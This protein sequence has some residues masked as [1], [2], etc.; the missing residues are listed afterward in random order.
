MSVPPIGRSGPPFFAVVAFWA[1]VLGGV[2]FGGVFV[3]N[4][5]ALGTRTVDAPISAQP[6]VVTVAAGPVSVS[7]PVSV[8]VAI[9]PG[10]ISVPIPAP[11]K[12]SDITSSIAS[13]VKTVLPDWQGSDRI[14]ILLLG[15][16]KRDD[17]PVAGTRS[18]TII[19]ASIDPVTKSAS[20]VS[21]PRDTW[22][23]IPGC[24]PRHE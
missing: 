16:D 2:V 3:A 9:K 13:V 19:L 24:T 12:P 1:F 11:V 14:N 17:E 22:V 23:S 8:P 10:S 15:I 18:D 21:L 4:W 5:R 6:N 7:V 20:L